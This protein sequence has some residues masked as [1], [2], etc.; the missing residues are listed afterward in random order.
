[1]ELLFLYK[2]ILLLWIL[3]LLNRLKKNY[4]VEFEIF[5]TAYI[6]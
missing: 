2:N 3:E 4:L 5:A 1:M 6:L